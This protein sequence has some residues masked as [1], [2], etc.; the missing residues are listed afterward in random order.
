MHAGA[1]SSTQDHQGDTQDFVSSCSAFVK[2]EAAK[3]VEVIM[4]TEM[5]FKWCMSGASHLECGSVATRKVLDRRVSQEKSESCV[6][7]C[8]RSRS[9]CKDAH[10]EIIDT[11]G[12]CA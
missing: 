4:N 2:P 3:S 6:R 10:P 12:N 1:P 11:S 5:E 8:H 9:Q 7:A